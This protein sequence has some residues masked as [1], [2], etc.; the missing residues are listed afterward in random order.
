MSRHSLYNPFWS[1]APSNN[2]SLAGTNAFWAVQP[3][4]LQISGYITPQNT[5]P[6]WNANSAPPPADGPGNHVVV[7]GQTQPDQYAQS[8]LTDPLGTG[9]D[10]SRLTSLSN[11]NDRQD[12]TLDV[13]TL[14][15]G[16]V[17]QLF[18][19]GNADFTPADVSAIENIYMVGDATATF[20]VQQLRDLDV[21]ALQGDGTAMLR[22]MNDVGSPTTLDAREI[23][24]LGIGQ[25]YLDGAT[26]LVLNASDLQTFSIDD[27][28]GGGKLRVDD[29][30]TLDLGP[31]SIADA[32]AWDA[33]LDYGTNDSPRYHV[34][35]TAENLLA[36]P[37]ILD[38]ASTVEITDTLIDATTAAELT[39]LDGFTGGYAVADTL[40]ALIQHAAT[41]EDATA[42]YLT[43]TV[44]DLGYLREE[45][46]AFVE[47]AENSSAYQWGEIGLF[48]GDR[49]MELLDEPDDTGTITGT[50][51][52]EV[53]LG[54]PG[55]TNVLDAS[56]GGDNILRARGGEDS[57]MLGGSGD[58]DFVIVGDLTGGGKT[59]GS[60][61]TQLLGQRLSDL[62]FA[63]Y[64]EDEN[65]GRIVIRGGEGNDTL[66]LIGSTD[67]S[68]F[69][70]E[71]V[72][73]LR[74][75]SE[76][77]ASFENF[78]KFQTVVGDGRSTLNFVDQGQSPATFRLHE[79]NEFSGIGRLNIGDNVT[80]N[81]ESLDDL[82]GS[83]ILTG[84]GSLDNIGTNTII[85]GNGMTLERG[86]STLGNIDVSNTRFIDSYVTPSR[87]VTLGDD[88]YIDIDVQ[89]DM[90]AVGTG[91]DD[92]FTI[93]DGD[94]IVSGNA[95]DD[96]YQIV[97]A[98]D[99]AIIN[100]EGR[101]TL[102][103]SQLTE[104]HAVNISLQ[105]NQGGTVSLNAVDNWAT[106]RFSLDKD[107]DGGEA[108][109]LGNQFNLMPI[110][111]TSGSMQGNR[112][113]EAK[114]S[115]IDMLNTF[116][117]AGNT[118]VKIIDFD[119]NARPVSE[120]WVDAEEA[121]NQSSGLSA[122]GGTNFQNAIDK[123]MDEWQEGQGDIFNL[124]GNNF[125][126]FMTDGQSSTPDVTAWHAF[127]SDNSI[128][129]EALAVGS[130]ANLS[131][132]Q[133]IAYDGVR[134][135][136]IDATD[137]LNFAELAGVL[138][139][140]TE[141]E[142]I[143]DVV[144]SPGDDVITGNSRDNRIDFSAGGDN[145]YHHVDGNDV[146]LGGEGYDTI[147]FSGNQA[148]WDYVATNKGWQFTRD[149]QTVSVDKQFDGFDFD[150]TG[151]SM[152]WTKPDSDWLLNQYAPVIALSEGKVEEQFKP[153]SIAA[154]I[155]NAVL[156]QYEENTG[157]FGTDTFTAIAAGNKIFTEFND[158]GAGSIKGGI[159]S[160]EYILADD[161][162]EMSLDD[163]S[164]VESNLNVEDA[165]YFL[166]FINDNDDVEDEDRVPGSS[167]MGDKYIPD[168]LENYVN[169]FDYT[170]YQ[171]Q[172]DASVYG[173]VIENE[174]SGRP[175]Y[176]QYHFHYLHDTWA[177]NH[178][179][180]W[181]FMQIRLGDEF[182]P[183]TLM[184]SIHLSSAQIE[185]AGTLDN[186]ITPKSDQLYSISWEDYLSLEYQEDVA[187][188]LVFVAN[189]AHAT[190]LNADET[191]ISG[192]TDYHSGNDGR[193]FVPQKTFDIINENNGIF[194]WN[195]NADLFNYELINIDESS[196]GFDEWLTFNL[197]WGQE[198]DD[199][200]LGPGAID[201]NRWEHPETWLGRHEGGLDRFSS[202]DVGDPRQLRGQDYEIIDFIEE[203]NTLFVGVGNSTQEWLV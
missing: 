178:E 100:A 55:V 146:V 102:D 190:Y 81:I 14:F 65:G 50:E 5:N 174:D 2:A 25:L 107:R 77:T 161:F 16:G 48:G 194:N 99:K 63:D 49:D 7:T 86:L 4:P 136:V 94:Q 132:I 119:S 202:I 148:E 8:D 73:N 19:Y 12:T 171:N 165:T 35:D 91:L 79:L 1:P 133:D 153:I 20:T 43:D 115:L 131:S 41:I 175:E 61:T 101:A 18:V 67:F 130:G 176:L 192:L 157:P 182:F 173:R 203:E 105:N 145:T 195:R 109:Q 155:D 143:Q 80:V 38:A 150:D 162:F 87:G 196:Q 156:W 147:V 28:S 129:A 142:L 32:L 89:G 164:S 159:V 51:T 90:S 184:S 84:Q 44:N 93:D 54:E 75:Y 160:D 185:K 39:A 78:Q 154:F 158:I 141:S 83:K 187:H 199:S 70:I 45:Q 68:K 114:Q 191:N 181:E 57:T 11:L 47:G 40:A 198:E 180:E 85:L 62:G 121:N 31:L 140:G 104:A 96:I 58:D 108:S 169:N 125:I 22:L 76:A 13:A 103:F 149:E 126:F 29:F 24:F 120:D 69:D 88:G 168:T 124:G 189:E 144:G 188:P 71:D 36:Q 167:T 172:Y 74:L 10:L 46:I 112:I 33:V 59:D 53:L 95:G 64:R 97:G 17:N 134:S 193:V 200:P 60:Q 123:A 201:D 82:G 9:V 42:Y 110:V 66:H 56:A 152:T 34:I 106:L 138:T 3:P 116:S 128:R 183:E 151:F 37:D 98:G 111:D 166:D 26:T 113:T 21:N 179:G 15:E 27:I 52:D 92:R 137:V 139:E 122:G 135:E 6:F 30:S 118:A 117:G 23:D 170:S 72:E 177:T 163:P 127:L 197:R 186:W